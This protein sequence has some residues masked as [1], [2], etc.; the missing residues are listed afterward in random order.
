MLLIGVF[1]FSASAQTGALDQTASA[2]QRYAIKL[3]RGVKAGDQYHV[4]C[5]SSNKTTT[6]VT[7]AGQFLRGSE[8]GFTIELSADVTVLAATLNGWATRKR[9]TVLSSKLISIS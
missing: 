9:F 2:A 8:D 4:E 6:N 3:D 5:A 7:V 1:A